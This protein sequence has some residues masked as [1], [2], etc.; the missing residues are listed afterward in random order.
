M[1]AGK[2]TMD[3]AETEAGLSAADAATAQQ[4]SGDLP[5]LCVGGYMTSLIGAAIGGRA[6]G[7]AQAVGRA[8]ANTASREFSIATVQ[9][10]EAGNSSILTT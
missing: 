10:T 7:E 6:I 9:T 8:A 2:F 3:V 5:G 4:P 1:S